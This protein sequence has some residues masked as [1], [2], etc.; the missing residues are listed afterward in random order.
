MRLYKLLKTGLSCTLV[1]EVMSDNIDKLRRD[2]GEC[3]IEEVSNL[4]FPAMADSTKWDE[5]TYAVYF[6]H[7]CKGEV[8]KIGQG[9][10]MNRLW[11]QLIPNEKEFKEDVASFSFV[12]VKTQDE[13]KEIEKKLKDKFQKRYGRPP[14]YG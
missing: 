8:L 12:R 14:K 11:I 1:G 9:E 7:S 6:L 3:S 4:E 2:W 13:A 5:M 10:L